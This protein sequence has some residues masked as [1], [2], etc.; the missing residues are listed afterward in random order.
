M[1]DLCQAGTA[2]A[3]T[4]TRRLPHRFLYWI[5]SES[6]IRWCRKLQALPA[7]RHVST[8]PSPTVGC[9]TSFLA[10]FHKRQI[11]TEGIQRPF[12]CSVDCVRRAVTR[13]L[14]VTRA[15]VSVRCS[16]QSLHR[17]AP[18][19]TAHDACRP[20]WW[21]SQCARNARLSCSSEQIDSSRML[22]VNPQFLCA[23]RSK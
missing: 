3:I 7:T 12:A 19:R 16:R 11:G 20:T 18:H 21:R 6:L 4:R 14:R 8:A 23:L 15:S 10:V 13:Q 22:S 1:R 9:S 5:P 17:T 2:E